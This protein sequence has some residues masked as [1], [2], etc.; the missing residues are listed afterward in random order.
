MSQIALIVTLCHLHVAFLKLFF[1]YRILRTVIALR[2]HICQSQAAVHNVLGVIPILNFFVG[3][4]TANL[5]QDLRSRY[6]LINR[7]LGMVHL[8]NQCHYNLA[9]V[10]ESQLY[11]MLYAN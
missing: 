1:K 2:E 9:Q 8:E 5:H 4:G 6:Q 10:P 3:D 7:Y 11:S